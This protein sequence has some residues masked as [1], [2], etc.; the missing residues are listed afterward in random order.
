ME[1]FLSDFSPNKLEKLGKEVERS[2]IAE[3]FEIAKKDTRQ[4]DRRPLIKDTNL[5]KWILVDSGA[6]VTIWPVTEAAKAKPDS[7]LVLRAVNG[8]KIRTEKVSFG[9]DSTTTI[10]SIWLS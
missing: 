3:V 6:A 2:T 7:S 4:G 8:E 10:L 9:G 5:G 1:T